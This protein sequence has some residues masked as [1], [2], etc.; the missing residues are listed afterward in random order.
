[1]SPWLRRWRSASPT[2]KVRAL[3]L[4]S[5]AELFKKEF[6]AAQE[7]NK[8]AAGEKKDDSDAAAKA[9]DADAASKAEEKKE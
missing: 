8:Q 5:D 7:A 1:M 3:L 2:R 4:T 6:E 9:G